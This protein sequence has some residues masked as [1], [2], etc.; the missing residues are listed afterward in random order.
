MSKRSLFYIL[1][2]FFTWWL[3]ACGG[4][5]P[6][7]ATAEPLFI[8]KSTPDPCAPENIAGEVEKVHALMREFDDESLLASNTPLNQLNPS[9]STLQRIR[10]EAE[11][12]SVPVCLVALKE[13][14]LAHMNT[15]INTLLGF[16]S[17]SD[18]GALS[19]SILLARQQHDE[20]T[21]ELA[22]V[23]GLTVIA[24]TASGAG[25]GPPGAIPTFQ[26]TPVSVFNPGPAIVNLREKPDLNSQSLGILDVGASTIA[27]GRNTDGSWIQIAVPD[28]PGL[29]VWVFTALI[30]LT[31]PPEALPITAP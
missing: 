16:L 8:L 22:S 28:Q 18:E 29:T 4:T 2:C 11:D 17:G 9:I 26:G 14:Q 21:L 6:P 5:A 27:V 3:V 25:D 1:I 24:P 13:H 19:Q 30:Q 7:T 15:V 23:L 10:R 31:G 20:Y 12:Q